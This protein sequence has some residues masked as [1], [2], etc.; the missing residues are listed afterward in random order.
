MT[1]VL[2]RHPALVPGLLFAGFLL[3]APTFAARG[4]LN[5]LW[6]VAIWTVVGLFVAT[7]RFRAEPA[8]QDA[9]PRRRVLR[10][11]AA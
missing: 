4:T 10:R 2:R 9:G 7:R 11:A 5:D 1:A 3:L 6:N 8:Q